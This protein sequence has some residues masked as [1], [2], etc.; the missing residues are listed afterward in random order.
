VTVEKSGI[1]YR[2]SSIGSTFAGWGAVLR[3]V[4][5]D[6]D[7]LRVELLVNILDASGLI[8][9]S[10]AVSFVG[11]PAGATYFAGGESIF[12]GIPARIEVTVRTG[13][14]QRK[15]IPGLPPVSNVRLSEGLFG[16][17]V[18]G[19]IANPYAQT[20]SSIARITYVALDAAGNVI[21][22]GRTYPPTSLPP[23]ARAAFSG[24][25]EGLS[26][27]QVARVEVSV[28]PEVD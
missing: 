28:E 7:A 5:P 6:E 12:S 9:E 2:V 13:A 21:G 17:E 15:S 27:S 22:G 1:A 10:E 8:L 14:R 26:A 20:L 11:I 4:S 16:L 25:L 24:D 18:L 3:N 19:E 23:G